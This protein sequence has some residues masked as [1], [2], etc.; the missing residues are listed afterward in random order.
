M[1]VQNG[2]IIDL[3]VNDTVT[4]G[5][6]LPNYSSL[7]NVSLDSRSVNNQI[8]D[9]SNTTDYSFDRRFADRVEVIAAKA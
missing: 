6:L 3:R 5:D 9:P 1:N 8:I 7:A 2:L 4:V